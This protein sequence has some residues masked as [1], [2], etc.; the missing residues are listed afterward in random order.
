MEQPTEKLY[1]IF[2]NIIVAGTGEIGLGQRFCKIVSDTWE[3]KRFRGSE[4]DVAKLL[5]ALAIQDFQSTFVPPGN[6]GALVAFPVHHKPFLCEFALSNF[7]PELK[8]GRL[9]YASMGSAQ[10]ITD[11]FLGLMR[12]VF[13]QDGLPD[14]NQG[15]FAV[16]WALDHAISINPGGVN[17]PVRIAVLERVQK[18]DLRARLLEDKD[19]D[20]HRQNIDGA[21]QCLR[22]YHN[23]HTVCTV[24]EIKDVPRK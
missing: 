17:G 9:W 23:T 18:T 22:D 21:K 24:G 2:D 3:A 19:L 16:T 1:V 12:E 8:T 10:S 4:I 13:W 11:P 6:Y 15:I 14:L 5:A 7:Q 20:E